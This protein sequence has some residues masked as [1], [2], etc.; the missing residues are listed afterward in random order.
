MQFEIFIAGK[1]VPF[2]GQ[3]RFKYDTLHDNLIQ[4]YPIFVYIEK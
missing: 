4:I 2:E 3:S 1:I